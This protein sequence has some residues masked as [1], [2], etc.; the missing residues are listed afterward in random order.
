M[1]SKHSQAQSLQICSKV[2][3]SEDLHDGL[4]SSTLNPSSSFSTSHL[5]SS[6]GSR[7]KYPHNRDVRGHHLLQ[8]PQ[9]TVYV[10][11]EGQAFEL[12]KA[13]L[14]HNSLFFQ[15]VFSGGLTET[16]NQEL[17]FEE[18]PVAAFEMLTEVLYTGETWKKSNQPPNNRLSDCLDFLIL[19]DYIQLNPLLGP[20]YAVTKE[21]N[22]LLIT[23]QYRIGSSTWELDES[24]IFKAAYY[25]VSREVKD[26][27]ARACVLPFAHS[28]LFAKL[29]HIPDH[30]N[31]VFQS[32]FMKELLEN[33]PKFTESILIALATTRS[34]DDHGI[35]PLTGEDLPRLPQRIKSMLKRMSEVTSLD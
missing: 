14:C 23:L 5:R 20:F 32:A 13:L 1:A 34:S 33:H 31:L 8:D 9:V 7:H 24:N 17:A 27:F 29:I 22:D 10:G 30:K 11:P 18:F 35:N 2:L 3:E 16:I 15:R 25:P 21:I 12:P 19:A 4:Q 26:L 6:T 28:P